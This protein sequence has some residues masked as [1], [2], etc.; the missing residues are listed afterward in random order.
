MNSSNVL[1]ENSIIVAIKRPVFQSPL[2]CERLVGIIIDEA[3]CVK[4]W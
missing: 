3:H 1:F 4:K 2:V